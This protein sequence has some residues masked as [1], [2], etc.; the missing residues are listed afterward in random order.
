MAD[1]DAVLLQV[2]EAEC[3]FREM[4]RWAGVDDAAPDA[5]KARGVFQEFCRL[6]LSEPTVLLLTCEQDS[7]SGTPGLR[8]CFER[9]MSVYSGTS[10]QHTEYLT[11]VLCYPLTP[12]TQHIEDDE[13]VFEVGSDGQIEDFFA[14][15]EDTR[16][17]QVLMYQFQ[18][19]KLF[20]SQGK[21]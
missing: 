18:P 15:V 16:S 2:H 12:E 11:C 19:Q 10:Y 13:I 7:H 8:L 17:F 5:G 9:Q 4:L 20:V 1:T 3:Y 6:P 14:E 21:L